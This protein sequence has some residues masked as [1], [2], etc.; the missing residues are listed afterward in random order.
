[1]SKVM[2]KLWNFKKKILG[3]SIPTVERDIR[4]TSQSMHKLVNNLHI[5][6]LINQ[7]ANFSYRIIQCGHGKVK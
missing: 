7:R 6:L 4:S 3:I 2:E 5:A 1:M